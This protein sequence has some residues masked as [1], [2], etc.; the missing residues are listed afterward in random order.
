MNIDIVCPWFARPEITKLH[1]ESVVRFINAAPKGVNVTY[2]VI[3]SPEDSHFES[4]LQVYEFARNKLPDSFKPIVLHNNEPVGYKLNAGI[5]SILKMYKQ[6]DFELSPLKPDSLHFIMNIGSDDMISPDYWKHCIPVLQS[7]KEMIIGINKLYFTDEALTHAF[8]VETFRTGALR[9]LRTWAVNSLLVDY[10]KP[11]YP[12]INKGM[13]G[14][15]MHN[16]TDLGYNY[17]LIDAPKAF[18]LDVKS[19][20]NITAIQIFFR[21]ESQ[22][23]IYSVKIEEII[24]FLPNYTPPSDAYRFVLNYNTSDI[25][26]KGDR[27]GVMFDGSLQYMYIKSIDYNTLI[28]RVSSTKN[29]LGQPYTCKTSELIKL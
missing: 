22:C 23:R 10:N 26:R 24:P 27:V 15:S 12:D 29:G 14:A 25:L 5:V 21:S 3:I 4:L 28:V 18:I 16:L 2:T 11:L 17:E 7:T 20:T 1:V 8:Y 19:N 6:T 9:F 13:D